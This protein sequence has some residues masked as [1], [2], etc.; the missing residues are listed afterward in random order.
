MTSL[1]TTISRMLSGYTGDAVIEPSEEFDGDLLRD[2]S[3]RFVTRA[4]AAAGVALGFI[5]WLLWTLSATTTTPSLIGTGATATLGDT[6]PVPAF[7][8]EMR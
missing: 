8:Q 4:L 3:R 6:A 5:A 2:E 7:S 1:D